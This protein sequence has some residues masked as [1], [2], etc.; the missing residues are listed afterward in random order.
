MS[1]MR[2]DAISM[3]TKM[4]T[5]ANRAVYWMRKSQAETCVAW[6]W[7]E[8]ECQPDQALESATQN[9]RPEGDAERPQ[10]DREDETHGRSILARAEFAKKSCSV[11]VFAEYG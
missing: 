1:T 8:E 6:F 2:R 10:E 5:A 3:T 11:S 9:A 7:I 4:Y